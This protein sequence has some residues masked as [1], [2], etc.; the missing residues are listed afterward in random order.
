MIQIPCNVV[1]PTDKIPLES[2]V[3]YK[4]ATHTRLPHYHMIQVYHVIY[5][6]ST[7]AHGGAV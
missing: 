2:E 1:H 6:A 3:Q 4:H 5:G 7:V